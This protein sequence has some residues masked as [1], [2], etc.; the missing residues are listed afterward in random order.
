MKKMVNTKKTP[1]P[2]K[3]P[4]KQA[5]TVSR[6]VLPSTPSYNQL[7]VEEQKDIEP[8]DEPVDP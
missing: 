5:R 4:A 1:S 7:P 2:L 6:D 3:E 8:D